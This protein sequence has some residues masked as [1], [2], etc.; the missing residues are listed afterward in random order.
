[1]TSYI[2]ESKRIHAQ[3][4]AESKELYDGGDMS[5]GD[6]LDDI[7]DFIEQNLKYNHDVEWLGDKWDK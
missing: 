1:M 6:A 4:M 7:A 5:G 3:L 2:E